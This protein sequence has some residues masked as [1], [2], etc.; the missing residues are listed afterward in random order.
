MPQ[1]RKPLII[2]NQENDPTVLQPSDSKVLFD[3][4]MDED[5]GEFYNIKEEVSMNDLIKC[6][7]DNKTRIDELLEIGESHQ[8]TI[9]KLHTVIKEI[10][11]NGKD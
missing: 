5:T 4:G 3:Y 9:G 10:R 2:D 7:K 11:E 1:F 8:N 6:W